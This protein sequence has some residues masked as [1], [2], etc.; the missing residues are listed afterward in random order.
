MLCIAEYYKQQGVPN[1]GQQTILTLRDAVN[2]LATY[3]RMGRIVPEFNMD[4]IRELIRQPFRVVYRVE[5]NQTIS[6]I[7]IWRSERLLTL[8]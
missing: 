5:P 3:P 1:I 2:E 4:N 7:R 8:A 6:V